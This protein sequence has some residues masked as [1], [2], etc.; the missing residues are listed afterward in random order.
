VQHGRRSV[1]HPQARRL[2]ES[3]S[4]TWANVRQTWRPAI[5]IVSNRF[6]S[7]RL[8][9][10]FAAHLEFAKDLLHAACFKLVTFLEGCIEPVRL[11]WIERSNLSF[12]GSYPRTMQLLRQSQD[13]LHRRESIRGRFFCRQDIDGM[14]QLLLAFLHLGLVRIASELPKPL[15]HWNNAVG[16]ESLATCIRDRVTTRMPGCLLGAPN[17]M[18]HHWLRGSLCCSISRRQG[19]SSYKSTSARM[20]NEGS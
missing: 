17:F 3:N 15:C 5:V 9:I 10:G 2:N 19:A 16:F 6:L 13:G 20:R 4:N 7:N 18:T 8:F 12:Q 14:A 11:S 1:K